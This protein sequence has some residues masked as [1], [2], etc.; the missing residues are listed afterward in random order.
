MW[1]MLEFCEFQGP[2]IRAWSLYT[3]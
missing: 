1:K 3:R 2:Y